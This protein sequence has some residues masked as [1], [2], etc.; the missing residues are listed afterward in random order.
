MTVIVVAHR[1]STILLADTVV[2]V[3]DGRVVATGTHDELLARDDYRALVT[4]YE[5]GEG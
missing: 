4:A 5:Q 1:I 2:Y 3:D